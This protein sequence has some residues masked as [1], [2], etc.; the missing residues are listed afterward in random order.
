MAP[1]RPKEHGIV[2]TAYAARVLHVSTRTVQRWAHDPHNHT[3]WPSRRG[4]VF[5][6]DPWLPWKAP[7]DWRFIAHRLLQ[8]SAVGVSRATL[9]RIRQG[10]PPAPSTQAKIMLAAEDVGVQF[11]GAGE[12]FELGIWVEDVPIGEGGEDKTT[13]RATFETRAV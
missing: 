13:E 10:N 2:S 4:Q 7:R 6:A 8:S 5:L 1:R 3:C 12:G 9:Y 11:F